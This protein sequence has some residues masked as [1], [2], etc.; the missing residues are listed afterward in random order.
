MASNHSAYTGYGEMEMCSVWRG[1]GSLQKSRMVH[2]RQMV[3]WSKWSKQCSLVTKGC[4]TSNLS[5]WA[6]HKARNCTVY[7]ITETSSLTYLVRLVARS[8]Q[9]RAGVLIHET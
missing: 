3:H 4:N 5:G 7:I 6:G 9:L 8:M 2:G 1:R